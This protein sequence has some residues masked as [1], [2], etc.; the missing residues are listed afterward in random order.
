VPVS[1]RHNEFVLAFEALDPVPVQADR[2]FHVIGLK[3]E[4][5]VLQPL[6]LAGEA[7]PIL[8]HDYVI[9]A[10]SQRGLDDSQQQQRCAGE[11]CEVQEVRC[12]LEA[13]PSQAHDLFPSSGLAVLAKQFLPQFDTDLSKLETIRKESRSTAEKQVTV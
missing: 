5:A 12:I 2:L 1:Q 10:L 4:L 7:V 11:S 13:V 6:D 8:H 3:G 9:L